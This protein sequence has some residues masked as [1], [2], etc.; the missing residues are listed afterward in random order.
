MEVRCNGKVVLLPSNATV[1]TLLGQLG[2]DRRNIAVERNQAVVPRATWDD[3][4]LAPGDRI[5]VVG[6]VGGG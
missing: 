2:F 6:F 4:P 3:T 1:A 5:E